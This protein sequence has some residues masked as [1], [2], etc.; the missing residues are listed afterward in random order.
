MG[1]GGKFTNDNHDIFMYIGFCHKGYLHHFEDFSGQK[2][3]IF[4]DFWAQK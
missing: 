2:Y 4:E 3:H 1:E